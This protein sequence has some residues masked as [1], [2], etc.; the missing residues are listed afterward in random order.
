MQNI[1][2]KKIYVNAKRVEELRKL[3]ADLPPVPVACEAANG[4]VLNG[5]HPQ[6]KGDNVKADDGPC[7]PMLLLNFTDEQV[8]PLSTMRAFG[9]V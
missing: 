3:E 7:I 1:L 8:S 4:K 6:G 5:K 9:L 2:K